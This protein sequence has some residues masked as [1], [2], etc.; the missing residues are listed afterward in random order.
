[1]E[2]VGQETLPMSIDAESWLRLTLAWL[3][4]RGLRGVDE[5]DLE[6]FMRGYGQLCVQEA[7][8]EH[9]A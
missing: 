4:N 1:M 8:P 9:E 2:M 3:S 6:K 7:S 5:Q